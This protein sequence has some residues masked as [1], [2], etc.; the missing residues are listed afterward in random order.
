MHEIIKDICY[1][2]TGDISQIHVD[3][4]VNAANS[5]LLGGGGVDGAIHQAAGPTLYAACRQIREQSLPAGLPPGE[6]VSTHAGRLPA[7][8]VIH[9]VGPVWS[10]GD[11]EES[12]I[13]A[14]CYEQAIIEAQRLGCRSIAFPS[15][16]TG[17]YRFPK[18]QATE[19]AWRVV[20]EYI[21]HTDAPMKIYLIFFTK[22]DEKIFLQATRTTGD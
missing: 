16:S 21:Q 17:V 1:S 2:C 18:K 6:V 9:T 13:L 3:A 10:G 5:S 8:Y 12:L 4:I 7:E 14:S 22:H 15:I 20:Y 11:Q 19:I